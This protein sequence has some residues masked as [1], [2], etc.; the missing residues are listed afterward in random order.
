MKLIEIS[1]EEINK[2]NKIKRL[3]IEMKQPQIW[4]IKSY[5]LAAGEKKGGGRKL[6]H[7]RFHDHV[8]MTSAVPGG[9]GHVGTSGDKADDLFQP[10]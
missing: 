8:H 5:F 4:R 10:L 6:I 1:I 9:K 7:Q 2:K 3:E